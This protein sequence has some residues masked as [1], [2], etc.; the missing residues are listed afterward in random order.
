MSSKILVTGQPAVSA[1]LL[2]KQSAFS[3]QKVVEFARW[4]ARWTNALNRLK[5][6]VPKL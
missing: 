6:W 5:K 1:Q 4:S 2:A 3:F